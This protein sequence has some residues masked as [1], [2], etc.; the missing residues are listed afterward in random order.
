VPWVH[1]FASWCVPLLAGLPLAALFGHHALK[2]VLVAF[3]VMFLV[4]LA[5]FFL[6]IFTLPSDRGRG[7]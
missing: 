4:S 5:A 3:G 1:F 6:Y 7:N 2:V